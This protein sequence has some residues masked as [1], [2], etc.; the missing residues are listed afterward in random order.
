MDI[1]MLARQAYIQSIGRIT[2]QDRQSLPIPVL[3]P[4]GLSVVFLYS[5]SVVRPKQPVI[6]YT[7]R[8]LVR[9]SATTGNIVEQREI[10]PEEFGQACPPSEIIG[11]HTLPDGMTLDEYKRMLDRLY[12]LYEILLP[13]FASGKSHAGRG[14]GMVAKEFERIFSILSEQPLLPY[15]RATGKDFFDWIENIS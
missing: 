13:A 9:L 12:E 15:Y 10:M 6:L 14:N 1:A 4:A 7:P 5:K 8:F 2:D 3:D 11:T